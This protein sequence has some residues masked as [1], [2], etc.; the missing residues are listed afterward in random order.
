MAECIEA[1]IEEFAASVGTRNAWR[2]RKWL[3]E[4]AVYRQPEYGSVAEVIY[5]AISKGNKVYVCEDGDFYI[6]IGYGASYRMTP[7]V[8]RLAK[9]LGKM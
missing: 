2:A 9:Y 5:S 6:R 4:Q 7:F 3:H 8:A 1:L